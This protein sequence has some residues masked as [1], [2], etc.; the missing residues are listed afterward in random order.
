MD[1]SAYEAM[2]GLAQTFNMRYPLIDGS[3]N[4]GSVNGESAAAMR[5]TEARLSPFGELLLGDIDRLA[6][7]KDN[8]D[9]SRQ[10]AIDLPGFFLNLLCN[11]NMG[12]SV[13]F[14]A[15]FAPHYAK[16]IYNALIK[17]I[18]DAKE[19]KETDIDKLI[20]IVKAPDFPTGATII[21]GAEMSNIYKT[22][23]GS[24]TLRSKYVL[25]KDKI[26]YTE[27]PYKVTPSSIVT[28]IASLNIPDI[29][30]V[31]DETSSRTGIRIV[32]DLKKGANSEWII[33]K[34]FKDTPLQSNYNVNMIAIMDNKPK[35]DLDL[36]TMLYFYF[37]N[38]AKIHY[39]DLSLQLEDN[40]SKLKNVETMLKVIENID[41]II[42]IIKEENAPKNSLQTKLN[43]DEEE[44]DYILNCKLNSISKASKEDLENKKAKYTLEVNR[45]NS[46]ITNQNNFLEDLKNKFINIRDS[47]VFKNDKR[48]TEIQNLNINN[49]NLDVK[50]FIKKEPVIITYSNKG[51]IKATRPDEFKTNKRNAM[52]VKNKT[53]RE[54]EYIC[55]MLTLDTHAELLLFSDLGKCYTLPVYK[56]PIS[57]RNG[58]T[59]SI[60]NYINM[61]DGEHILS[62]TGILDND[63]IDNNSVIMTTQA[64]YIKRIDLSLLTKS[65]NSTVG[66]KA[67]TLQENDKIKGVN[68]CPP[69]TDIVIFTSTGRGLKINIDDETKP[70]RSMGKAAR[71]CSAIKLKKDEV[72][73][74]ASVLDENH[75]II[76]VTSKGYGKRLEVSSFKDQKRYQTPINYMAKITEV[77]KIINGIIINKDED[78]LITT[79]QSQTLRL[80]VDNIASSSRTAKGLKLISIKDETDKVIGASAVKR[81]DNKEEDNL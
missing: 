52:G 78:L 59:K 31:R 24:I 71:G 35:I 20:E 39:K 3:G 64:G 79:Q 33:N 69:N 25:E 58:V 18:E 7:T 43:F 65:R 36:K 74:N 12:I 15:K 62:I 40:K 2:V 61:G 22:G 54:D 53:L 13:G 42:K 72:V 9:N 32:V 80:S 10:E 76:L 30:D 5:Y 75:S 6:E 23:K 60:N 1:Q 34:L 70:L 49:K 38:I 44:A 27:I 55:H 77:G 4:F 46:I 63:N 50:A 41:E 11:A 14:A 8:F 73:V 47:K 17:I 68:I 67:I 16:D 57:G 26:I 19:N 37:N 66:T 81:E 51:M 28:A 48:R 21:N 45:L 29:K 56:I